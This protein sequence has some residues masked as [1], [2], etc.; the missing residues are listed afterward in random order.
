VAILDEMF[1]AIAT[2]TAS[3]EKNLANARELFDNQ[4]NAV[5]TRKGSGWGRHELQELTTKIGSGATPT[6][7]SDSYEEEGISLIRS[8]NVHDRDFRTQKPAF[9]GELTAD[10]KAGEHRLSEAGV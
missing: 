5:F 1:A 8:L 4:L 9:T 2:A 6:G 10:A 3:A 7:G